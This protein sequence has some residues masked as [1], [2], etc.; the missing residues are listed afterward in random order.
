MKLSKKIIALILVVGISLGTFGGLLLFNIFT[1]TSQY[2]IS[3]FIQKGPFIQGSSVMIQE[4]DNNFNPTG[5]VYSIET[6]D[7]FG[8]F[9]MNQTQISTNYIEIITEGYYFNEILGQISESTLTLRVIAKISDSENINI[10][11]LTTLESNRIKYLILHEGKTFIEAKIQAEQELLRIFNI[12]E[13]IISNITTFDQM[14]ISKTG[15]SNAILLAISATLQGNNTVG[16]LSELI[17]KIS[18]DIETDG[19]LDNP[20]Y[21]NE[22]KN[23]GISLAFSSIKSNLE[24]RYHN[25]GLTNLTVPNF[26]DFIDSDGDGIINLYDYTLLGP[27]GPITNLTPTFNWTDS[28]LPNA[29]YHIQIS[30]NDL[31]DN[32]I[33]EATNLTE[34]SYTINTTLNNTYPNYY[35]WRV[36]VIGEN[37]TESIWADHKNFT[38]DLTPPTPGNSGIISVISMNNNSISIGWTGATDDVSPSSALEYEVY[39][40]LSDNLNTIED[41]ENNGTKVTSDWYDFWLMFG[42]IYVYGLNFDTYYYF[43]I[44]VKDEAGNKGI[45]TSISS[46]TSGNVKWIFG[47]SFQIE[48]SPAINNGTIY[49]TSTGGVLYAIYP[50][51]TQKWNCTTSNGLFSSPSIDMSGTIYVGSI[52]TLYAIYPNGTQKWNFTTTGDIVSS[53]SIDKNGIIYVGTITGNLYAIYPNG[54]QKWNITAF[55]DITPSPIID[56]NGIIYVGSVSGT[57]Y[58]IYPNGTLKW[59]FIT[60]GEIASSPSIDKN[61]TIYVGN[62]V[63]NLYAIY[64]NGTQKWVSTVSSSIYSNPVIDSNGT[65]YIT[66]TNGNL[67][68]FYPNG[69]Q[70]WNFIGMVYVKTT[71]VIDSNG[72]IYVSS[73]NRGL[74][75][76]YPDGSKKWVLESYSFKESS[77]VIDIDKTIYIGLDY[78]LLAVITNSGS[79]LNSSW[80]MFNNNPQHTSCVNI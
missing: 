6:K 31:F 11:I 30:T 23:N 44:I 17:S 26:E 70:K 54:T 5:V 48:S 59:N 20:I 74:F 41:I 10:N 61:G 43:N 63:G 78:G 73:W 53:P 39:Y 77:P 28:N 33:E 65:I 52:G 42:Y 62:I 35:Y 60:G 7:D 40:S 36:F 22:I 46:S 13:D 80:P 67:Y 45:Y 18:S 69:T 16:E 72:T 79:L 56:K 15:I 4:L 38:I 68:A 49:V 2:N 29:S 51:G 27:T 47:T 9:S 12:P 50:N 32:I 64:P 76:I 21:I 57:L 75:A 34:S 3:G 8:S 19:T 71:P 25:L 37:D 1:T 24:Q 58:A 55:G 66:A 14:D